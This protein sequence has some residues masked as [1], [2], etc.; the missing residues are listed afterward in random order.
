MNGRR[1]DRRDN[2]PHAR[3]L[4]VVDPALIARRRAFRLPGYATLA[5]V[6]LDGEYVSPLQ[7]CAGS[8]T[9]PALVAYHWLEAD[10]ARAKAACLRKLGYLPNIIFNK[11]VDAALAQCGLCRGDVYMTQAF[12]LLPA[13][14][15]S[16]VPVRDVDA[17]FAAVT[18]FELQGRRVI[19]LGHAAALACK[20]NGVVPAAAV[21]HPSARGLSIGAK[22]AALARVIADVLA[23]APTS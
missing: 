4:A 20:R 5:D 21:M 2:C 17:S 18:R 3:N 8:P 14:R 13:H 22:A 11:V 23:S 15:S 6:G 19:A 12:H 1:P 16:V 9:G 7:I 10:T